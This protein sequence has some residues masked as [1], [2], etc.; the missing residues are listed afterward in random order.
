MTKKMAAAALRAFAI[1]GIL[2][3]ASA[4]IAAADKGQDH[5]I[6]EPGKASQA[7]R[8]ITVAVKDDTTFQPKMITVRSGET[9]RFVFKNTG[10]LLHE[11]NIGTPEMHAEHAKEMTEMLNSGAITATSINRAMMNMDSSKM[12]NM[13]HSKMGQMDHSKMGMSMKHDDP[14]SVL[15]EP[16]KS[17]ELIWKFTQAANLEFSCNVPG[18]REAGM[19]GSIKFT[20]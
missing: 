3:L 20:R 13:D 1:N 8:T 18:H 15:V 4:S 5:A 2:A 19:L 16:G 6:G 7:G 17:A 11:F 14:N 12:A 10:Q 9:I